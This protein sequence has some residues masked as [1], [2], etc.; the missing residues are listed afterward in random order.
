MSADAATH[1]P[2]DRILRI[3]AEGGNAPPA[4]QAHLENC[5]RCR[6]VLAE[7]EGELTLLRRQAA[8]AVPEPAQRFVLPADLPEPTPGRR[9]RWAWAAL[10]TGLS[11][12]L[13]ALFV[14][15]GGE[16]PL[17]GLPPAA[18]T[19]AAWQD[20]E[21]IEVNRLAENALPEAYLALSESLAGGYD[22]DFID[23]LIPPL[24]EES[25]S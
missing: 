18:P 24:D 3:V 6:A 12:A 25:L 23:F 15:V 10:G 9:R 14:W 1:I 20:P 13:L 11:A 7:I 16:K 4:E 21:M 5:G 22:E 8:L 19:T 2:E 17:P